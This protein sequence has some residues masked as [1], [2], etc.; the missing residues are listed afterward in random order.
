MNPINIKAVPYISTG[1][2]LVTVFGTALEV[3]V[4]LPITDWLAVTFIKLSE[5]VM[6]ATLGAAIWTGA[7]GIFYCVN[8]IEIGTF[9]G[10]PGVRTL[11][12][13]VVRPQT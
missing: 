10:L 8:E 9:G 6:E 12:A 5:V 2:G 3:W 7:A 4:A 11:N 1:T 13:L